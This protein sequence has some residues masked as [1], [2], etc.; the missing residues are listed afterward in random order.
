MLVLLLFVMLLAFYLMAEVCEK[1]FVESLEKISKNLK[2]SPEAS[3]ATLMAVGS[4]APELFVSLM[5][6][7]KPGEEAMGAGTI[8][9]SAIFNI[10]VIT[11][12]S[13]AVRQAFIIWQPVVR[14]MLFYS[15]SIILLLFAFRDGEISLFEI[16]LFLTVY[17]V[18]ILAVVKWKKI[19]KYK[20][21]DP[22]ELIEEAMTEKKWKK[23]F[24]PVDWLVKYTF[25]KP[26]K[27]VLT[28]FV[29]LVW[30][31]FLSWALVE[32]AVITADK[33][34]IPSV[35]I[36]LTI[37]AAGTS[38]P[39]LL[40]SIIVAKKGQSGMAIS[41]GIGSNIFDILICLGFPWLISY[42]FM[43][44][45]ITVATENLNSSIILLFATV[46]S[47]LFLFIIRKWNVGKY[48]GYF[49]IGLYLI[50][51]IWI[52]INTLSAN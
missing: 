38:V 7:F 49:L 30:I 48:S 31:I 2:L 16:I 28:F 43:G 5:A 6:L 24:A 9:G 42:V 51:L 37:L 17:V 1:Y 11:G 4:S 8:V 44:E 22:I 36:G 25:P 14:D 23:A 18:Y 46:V 26:E 29:S 12:A 27:Y 32:S 47:I 50:Y 39:D 10:L 20:D 40:S 35:V 13:V 33:L 19:F 21:D 52:L 45:K 41:N 34:G 15:L 3:G